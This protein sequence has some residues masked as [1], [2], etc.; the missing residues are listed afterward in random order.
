MSHYN[1]S[2]YIGK[3]ERK[4]FPALAVIIG[5]IIAVVVGYLAYVFTYEEEIAPE[6]EADTARTAAQERDLVVSF[7]EEY[8]RIVVA[9]AAFDGQG[10]LDEHL[11]LGLGEM[12]GDT[13]TGFTLKLDPE[14]TLNDETP[15]TITILVTTDT[16]KDMPVELSFEGNVAIANLAP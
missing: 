6:V 11:E 13:V 5:M 9:L 10:V 8:G 15:G 1:F 12:E 3:G 7:A 2:P 14:D 16:T 4:R